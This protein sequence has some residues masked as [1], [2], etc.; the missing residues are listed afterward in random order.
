MKRIFAVMLVMAF[1]LTGTMVFGQD[2]SDFEIELYGG[3][4][5][6]MDIEDSGLTQIPSFSIGARQYL[7]EAPGFRVGWA[8]FISFGLITEMEYVDPDGDKFIISIT[9]TMLMNGNIFL[10]ASVQGDIAPNFSFVADFGLAI[11]MDIASFTYPGYFTF[12]APYDMYNQIVIEFTTFK[13]GVG[14]NAGFQFS[15]S[16]LII[17]GGVNIGYYFSQFPNESII[18]RDST[19][20]EKDHTFYSL[21]GDSKPLS[22]FR[23]APYITVGW[24]F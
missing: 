7:M 19:K 20:Q 24:R 5:Y 22:L 21:S 12:L 18:L 13:M 2:D 8:A 3:F 4:H 14:A 10:G 23:A 16:S 1:I 17:E 15:A 6:A 11:G 9:D